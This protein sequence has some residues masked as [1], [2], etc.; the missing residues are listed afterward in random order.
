[1]AKLS[2]RERNIFIGVVAV[3]GIWVADQYAFTPY[4]ER[5]SAI[6]VD[7]ERLADELQKANKVVLQGRRDD[8]RWNQTIAPG[9]QAE[10]T[11][12]EG[13]MFHALREWSQESG[14]NL[15][16]MKS[17]RPETEKQFQKILVRVT[18]TGSLSQVA[19][20]LFRIQT[21]NIPARVVDVQVTSRKEGTDDLA[22]TL[23][24]ST[25]ALAPPPPGS[26]G[27][28]ARP[29]PRSTSM[30]TTAVAPAAAPATTTTTREVK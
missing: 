28:G 30:P 2:K 26:T 1:V 17:E 23:G 27:S 6:R 12:A 22:L 10:A 7:D 15:S 9:L 18:G 29:A 13:Q 3:V 16:S 24:V 11:A 19:R 8:R 4:T 5:L 14:F 20:L 25:L 21:A